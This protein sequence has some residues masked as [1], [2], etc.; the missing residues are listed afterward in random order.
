MQ[1][2]YA[3]TKAH[4]L[5][6]MCAAI[7]TKIKTAVILDT[8]KTVLI[9]TDIFRGAMRYAELVVLKKIKSVKILLIELRRRE[10]FLPNLMVVIFAK[11]ATENGGQ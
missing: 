3:F 10:R 4:H 8:T 6:L 1:K 2:G 9:K 7:V 11:S 5:V